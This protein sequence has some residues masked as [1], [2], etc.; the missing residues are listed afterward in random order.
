MNKIKKKRKAFVQQ[1]DCVA[2]VWCVCCPM[3]T[4]TQLICKAKN[5]R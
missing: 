4:M 2:C 5:Q 3:G 1:S